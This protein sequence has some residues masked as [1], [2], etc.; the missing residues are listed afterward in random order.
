[1]MMNTPHRIIVRNDCEMPTRQLGQT[2]AKGG[3]KLHQS[4]WQLALAITMAT[5]VTAM[6]TDSAVMATDFI[7]MATGSSVMVT[8]FFS[9]K[10]TGSYVTMATGGWLGAG[11]K[12][13]VSVPW[14]TSLGRPVYIL[15][16]PVDKGGVPRT[17]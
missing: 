9:A 10:G 5:G 14:R 2:T 11:T 15:G 12:A 7:A 3:L 13:N 1:M 8:G 16:R 17:Y 4:P 6:A